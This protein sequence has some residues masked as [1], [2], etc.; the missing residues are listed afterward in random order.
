MDRFQTLEDLMVD[1]ELLLS[2]YQGGE[3]DPQALQ[4]R[5]DQCRERLLVVFDG[6]STIRI[7]HLVTAFLGALE[8]R[9]ERDAHEVASWTAAWLTQRVHSG[10]IVVTDPTQN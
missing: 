3:R 8:G 1:M 4:E 7:L 9:S 2:S 6:W 5:V 10:Y